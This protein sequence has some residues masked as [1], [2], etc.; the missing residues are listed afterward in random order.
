MNKKNI[1]TITLAT[2]LVA[3][4]IGALYLNSNKGNP[5]EEVVASVNGANITKDELYNALVK[6]NGP[7]ALDA[8]ISDKIVSLE[9]QKQNITITEAETQAEL[10]KAINQYGGQEAFDQALLSYGYTLEAV[11]KDM[12]LNLKVKKMLEPQIKITEEEMKSYFEA[13]KDSF[14]K[15]GQVKASHILVASEEIAKEV[16]TKLTAGADF[17]QMAKEYSTD[18]SNKDK[19]GDLGFFS[20]GA[21]VPEFENAAFSLEIGKISDP[22]KTEFGYHIIKVIEK[23]EIKPATY[24]ENKDAVKEALLNEK[25]QTEYG[26]WYDAKYKE[27]KVENFLTK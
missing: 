23:Q 8:L 22:V 24:E 5:K 7:Q 27:Y 4:L 15:E 2:V 10:Q 20:K 3:V 13:N 26:T 19:G 12:E 9:L 21:M 17:A 18:T 6:E 14:Q 16:K 1:I 11:K 25:M